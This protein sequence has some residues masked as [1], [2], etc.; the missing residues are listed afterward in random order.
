MSDFKDIRSLIVDPAGHSKTLL[1]R[2]LVNLGASQ[3]F[4]VSSTEEA[5]LTLRKDSFNIVFCDELVGPLDPFAFMKALRRDLETRDVT[6]PVVLVSAGADIAKIKAARDAGMND[7]IVKPVSAMT[8][9]RKLQ[10]LIH[11]PRPFV[12]A[13]A[14]V[15]PDRRGSGERRQFGERHPESEDRRGRS[16]REGSVFVVGPRS[17]PDKPAQS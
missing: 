4:A 17:G 8:I 3:V 11:A 7:V 10:S 14:F 12:T 9:E 2:L 16:S 1:R 15:G 5:L 13:K 6:V